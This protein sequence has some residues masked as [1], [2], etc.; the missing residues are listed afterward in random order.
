MIKKYRNEISDFEGTVVI[1]DDDEEKKEK[2]RV[3]CSRRSGEK[4]FEN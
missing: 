4:T 3:I 1:I 2:M